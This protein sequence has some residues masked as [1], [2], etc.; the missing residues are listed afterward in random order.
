MFIKSFSQLSVEPGT[1]GIPILLVKSL[2]LGSFCKFMHLAS[3]K[4]KF[5]SQPVECGFCLRS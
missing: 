4:P 5:E 1:T 3:V 2:R